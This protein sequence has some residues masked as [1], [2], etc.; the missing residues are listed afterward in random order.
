MHKFVI[1]LMILVFQ[2]PIF[3][4]QAND[5]DKIDFDGLTLTVC[6]AQGRK[7]EIKV[8][9]STAT[10]KAEPYE[11]FGGVTLCFN[12]DEF[13]MVEAFA[14]YEFGVKQ[15]LFD[16]KPPAELDFSREL[17]PVALEVE[18]GAISLPRTL[19]NEQKMESVHERLGFGSFIELEREFQNN[20]LEEI[21]KDSITKQKEFFSYQLKENRKQLE[22]CCPEYIE[23][24]ETFL[25]KDPSSFRSF[26][27]LGVGVFRKKSTIEIRAEATDGTIR[28]FKIIDSN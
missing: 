9:G 13:E 28:T 26:R 18:L 7:F 20:Y 10:V 4:Q 15:Y 3:A 27:D 24:A 22:E 11:D 12:R 2:L 19:S 8:N 16:E 17:G 14:T 6:E 25:G 21:A 1:A 23:Q 5:P